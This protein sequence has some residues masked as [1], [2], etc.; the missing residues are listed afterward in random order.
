MFSFNDV[1]CLIILLPCFYNRWCFAPFAFFASLYWSNSRTT[2]GKTNSS[3]ASISS[4]TNK[5]V[6]AYFLFQ[7][8]HCVANEHLFFLSLICG[9]IVI[10][11]AN[12]CASIARPHPHFVCVFCKTRYE[13]SLN[14]FISFLPAYFIQ[15]K[16]ALPRT[17]PR[18]SFQSRLLTTEETL[19][20]CKWIY[21][22]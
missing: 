13:S 20:V 5:L 1:D 4:H 19:N 17:C 22:N 9:F 7:E 14:S 3:H 6:P 18:S 8:V 2:R 11:R 21:N 10:K 15:N 12:M 16:N